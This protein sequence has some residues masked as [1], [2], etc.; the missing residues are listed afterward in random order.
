VIPPQVNAPRRRRSQYLAAFV[1]GILATPLMGLA[2]ALSGFLPVDAVSSPAGWESRIGQIALEA[3]LAR[4]SHGLVDPT[5]EGDADLI[6]GMN[7][8]RND[9][10]G[11]HGDYGQRR[12]GSGLYPPVPQFDQRA[13][14]LTASEMF[15]AAKYG[16][17]YT[18]MGAWNVEITDKEIWQAVS[19]LSRLNDLSSAVNDAW[20]AKH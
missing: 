19:F 16:I 8:Y 4:R 13:P 9:C 18:G 7:T 11:C 5:Q 14:G 1:A 20:T 6:A 17:R 2:F 3:S 10:A 15:V 12:S